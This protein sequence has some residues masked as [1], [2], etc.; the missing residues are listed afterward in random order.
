[1]LIWDERKRLANIAKH[2]VDFVDVEAIWDGPVESWE[3]AREHYG[4]Q[5]I[6][7]LGWLH[8]RVMG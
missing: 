2:G 5:R 1:M 7:L 3:D 4:E 6:N 8:G